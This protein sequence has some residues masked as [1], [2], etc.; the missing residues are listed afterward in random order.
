MAVLV[1]AALPKVVTFASE[2]T[3]LLSM[4]QPNAPI[5]EVMSV[6]PFKA[7]AV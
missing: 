1:A 4:L 3:E 2:P 5:V 7:R 6:L